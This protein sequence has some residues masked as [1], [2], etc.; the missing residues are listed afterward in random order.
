VTRRMMFVVGRR[1]GLLCK[2]FDQPM[3]ISHVVYID[4]SGDT[5]LEVVRTPD[6]PKGATEWLVLSGFVVKIEHDSKM[7]TWVQDV[8]A[9]FT[10][11]R[12]DLHFNKLLPFKK[13][14]VCAQL[15]L[16]DCKCFVVMSNKKN[17]E[18]Y[19]NSRLDPKNKSWIYWFLARLLLERVTEYC[20]SEIPP[21]RCGTDKLRIIFSRRG[22]LMYADFEA[23]LT[24]LYWQSRLNSL[25][26]AYKDIKWPMI[27]WE[28]IRVLDHKERAGLQLADVVAGAFFQAVEMNRGAETEC[29]S[30][31]A[32]LLKPVIAARPSG[33]TIG[34]GLKTMP[35]PTAMNLM[36]SQKAL[37]EFYG[38]PKTGWKVGG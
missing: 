9:D 22:G 28:E 8:Q 26:L 17:M 19:K 32:N 7:V 27:D 36:E 15:A 14:L 18:K 20:E 35:I 37:F 1:R 33:W 11:K 29:D 25:T 24:K 30:N 34:Y 12:G 38:F 4:E 13:P 2:P 23:Y 5:G 3:P 10:S 21:E 16:K 6:D 31:C